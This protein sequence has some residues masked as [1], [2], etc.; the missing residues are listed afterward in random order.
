MEENIM[1]SGQSQG[2]FVVVTVGLAHPVSLSTDDELAI[3]DSFLLLLSRRVP[4]GQSQYIADDQDAVVV[5]PF[6]ADFLE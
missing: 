4:N 3:G 6:I 5:N 2:Q 1:R